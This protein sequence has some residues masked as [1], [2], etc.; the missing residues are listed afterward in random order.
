VPDCFDKY[1]T[2]S[3]C[4]LGRKKNEST[5]I[6]QRKGEEEEEEEGKRNV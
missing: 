2:G 3:D 4:D 6:K 5:K 1:H